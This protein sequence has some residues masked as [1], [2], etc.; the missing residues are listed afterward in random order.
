[1]YVTSYLDGVRVVTMA[2]NVPG[3]LA[4]ARL[5]Q[6]GA[7]VTKIEPPDGDPFLAVSPEWHA[8]LHA[9]VPIERL[10]LKSADGHARLMTLLHDADVFITS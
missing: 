9:G 10:D 7:R 6:A 4:A 8:E 2:Q 3:P 5:S 1:M